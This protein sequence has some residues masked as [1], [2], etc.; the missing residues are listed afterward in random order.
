MRTPHLIS[1][2]NKEIVGS[3]GIRSL[4]RMNNL[5]ILNMGFRPQR[6]IS[7]NLHRLMLPKVPENQYLLG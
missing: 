5:R 6:E 1:E 7:M 3:T 2:N 4:L